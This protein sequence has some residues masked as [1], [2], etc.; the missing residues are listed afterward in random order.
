MCSIVRISILFNYQ[1]IIANFIS[2]A[3]F[4][5]WIIIVITSFSSNFMINWS[6][7]PNFNFISLGLA[8]FIIVIT[9]FSSNLNWSSRPNFNFISLGLTLFIIVITNF[10]SNFMGKRSS[11]PN[12]NFISLGLAL[13]IIISPLL[14]KFWLLI[15]FSYL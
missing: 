9:S 5:D 3:N 15:I 8:L 11:R 12:F 7:R 4:Q 14:F 1:I 10:S 13:F 2:L 6:S